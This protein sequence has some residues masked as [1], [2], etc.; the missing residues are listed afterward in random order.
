M[1]TIT[2]EWKQFQTRY[3]TTVIWVANWS[4]KRWKIIT[5]RT[6]RHPKTLKITTK[7][8]SPRSLSDSYH[9][10][11]N[12]T[13]RS[14]R[15]LPGAQQNNVTDGDVHPTVYRTECR[16]TLPEA[17]QTIN[18]KAK[19]ILP[20]LPTEMAAEK[21]TKTTPMPKQYSLQMTRKPTRMT[22]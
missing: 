8:A 2:N 18:K 13:W 5:Q 9:C 7:R 10:G 17:N 14:T 12:F 1:V 11:K 21:S 20:K 19:D 6:E 15:E 22:C 3:R 16:S 4:Q